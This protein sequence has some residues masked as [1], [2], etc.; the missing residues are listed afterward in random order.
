M[1]AS[2]LRPDTADIPTRGESLRRRASDLLNDRA[3]LCR[4]LL[5]A[6]I[7]TVIVGMVPAFRSNIIAVISVTLLLAV[8]LIGA[9]RDT[10][11]IA[12]RRH[13]QLEL[14]QSFMASFAAKPN[15]TDSFMVLLREVQSQVNST[16]GAIFVFQSDDEPLVPLVWSPHS[17]VETLTSV[18]I[19]TLSILEGHQ[20]LLHH[21]AD[22]GY[23]DSRFVSMALR[24]NTPVSRGV[25]LLKIS[26]KLADEDAVYL[27]GVGYRLAEILRS[28]Q[29]AQA[30]VRQ[31]LYDER[32]VIARELHDSLAQSLSYL[33]IQVARIEALLN[34]KDSAK[35]ADY[36]EIDVVVQELR[37]NL[38]LAYQQLR[39]IITTFRLTTDGRSFSDALED[40]VQEFENRSS[41]VFRLDSRVASGDLTV[42]EEMHVLHI[43]REALS[44]VVRHSQAAC[45]EISL[46]IGPT[47][48]FN[49]AVDDD[50]IGF[51]NVH[52]RDRHHGLVIMQ[53]RAHTLGGDFRVL[54]SDLGGT[55]IEVSFDAAHRRAEGR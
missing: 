14:L 13:N 51:D 10:D 28:V 29:A 21:T 34:P 11:P 42:E 6:A 30:S 4:V 20:G 19:N 37:T 50:G 18:V 46:L 43:I 32:G 26:G 39:D 24:D 38:N 31:A 33:K 45:A 5:L 54:S 22:D 35:P 25:L 8:L 3:A 7:V 36:V 16:E 52:Q 2:G 48:S 23:S 53:Q 15:D 27:E 9:R 17:D 12:P 55:R 47:G 49:M 40:S 41:I 1:D 44:N